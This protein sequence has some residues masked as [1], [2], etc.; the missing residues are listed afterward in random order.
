MVHLTVDELYSTSATKEDPAINDDDSCYTSS[1][2]RLLLSLLFFEEEEE[3]D[4]VAVLESVLEAGLGVTT[5]SEVMSGFE[6]HAS[7]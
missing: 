1:G 2:P 7:F 4:I 3:D 5:A 6:N